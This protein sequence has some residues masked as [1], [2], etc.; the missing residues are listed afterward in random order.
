MQQL[1]SERASL[2]YSFGMATRPD[3][4]DDTRRQV[5][6]VIVTTN[7]IRLEAEFGDGMYSVAE[8]QVFGLPASE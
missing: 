3:P 6:P 2:T 5:L 7:A 8:I 1:T 4:L